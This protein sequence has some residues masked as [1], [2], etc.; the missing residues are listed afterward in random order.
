MINS[1][2]I[3]QLI[4]HRNPMIMVDA[5]L[6]IDKA[7]SVSQLKIKKDNVFLENF[8]LNESGI[9]EHMAQVAAV[10]NG[11]KYFK[12][13]TPRN[14]YVAAIQ[15][16]EFFSSPKTSETITTELKPLFESNEMLKAE[17]KSYIKQT[18][19]AQATIVTLLK[20]MSDD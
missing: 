2:K 4:P 1:I 8:L 6:S 12:E 18:L 14:G 20:P 10:H 15:K 9:L 11:Y 7:G 19:I 17:L 3:E 16:A 13:K 5:L